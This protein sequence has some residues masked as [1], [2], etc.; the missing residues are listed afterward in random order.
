MAIKTYSIKIICIF[1]YLPPR[2]HQVNPV[3]YKLDDL[4]HPAVYCQQ[5]IMDMVDIVVE[6]THGEYSDKWM[7]HFEEEDRVNNYLYLRPEV[8]V[9]VN[10]ISD[11]RY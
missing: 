4:C 10:L 2:D 6:N 9:F 8:F 1:S 5:L 11:H 3:M 7:E